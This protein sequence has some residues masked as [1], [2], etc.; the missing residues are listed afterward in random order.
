MTEDVELRSQAQLK[1]LDERGA[2]GVRAERDARAQWLGAMVLSRSADRHTG[3]KVV[4]LRSGVSSY[5]VLPLCR[6]PGPI[7]IQ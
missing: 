3:G 4:S 7:A 2:A 6:K 5:D 1:R